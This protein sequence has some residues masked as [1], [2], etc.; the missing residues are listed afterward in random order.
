MTEMKQSILRSKEVF[1]THE[2]HSECMKRDFHP[3]SSSTGRLHAEL[4]SVPSLSRLF[5]K[6]EEGDGDET[7]C[8]GRC[9]GA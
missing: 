6:G 9:G 2:V 4:H 3:C 7:R 5:R 8:G 1:C